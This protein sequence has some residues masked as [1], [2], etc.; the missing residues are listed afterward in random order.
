MN[1][2]LEGVECFNCIRVSSSK[3]D[4][5]STLWNLF[6]IRWK[7]F[8]L[9]GN[10]FVEQFKAKSECGMFAVSIWIF[11]F[12]LFGANLLIVLSFSVIAEYS[13]FRG[14]NSLHN[15]LIEFGVFEACFKSGFCA[16]KW[17]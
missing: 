15:L 8:K 5:M 1:L 12:D 17:M 6:A 7:L 16:A 4:I 10:C 3:L 11:E 2:T 14:A 13:G 9:L